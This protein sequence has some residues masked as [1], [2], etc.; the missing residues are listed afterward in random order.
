MEND[1]QR[2]IGIIALILVAGQSWFIFSLWRKVNTL[3]TTVTLHDQNWVLLQRD[4]GTAV[5]SVIVEAQKQV[6]ENNP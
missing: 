3:T 6:L 1:R 4:F 2:I 5:L